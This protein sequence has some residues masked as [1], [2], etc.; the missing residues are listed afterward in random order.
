MLL[1]FLKSLLR[2]RALA[3]EGDYPVARQVRLNAAHARA[4]IRLH[5]EILYSGLRIGGHEI[6]SLVE[7]ALAQTA[8]VLP[9]LKALHRPLASFF[10]ARY[11]LH[12][13]RL[14]GMQAECGVFQGTSALLLCRAAQADEPRYDGERL[15]LVDS[16]EGLSPPTHQDRFRVTGNGARATAAVGAGALSGSFQT[17]T[18]ALAAFPAARIHKGWIPEVLAQLPEASWSFVHVDVDLYEPTYAC[19]DFFYPRLCPGG[20]IVCDDYGS[21]LFPGA[22]RAWDRYCAERAIPFVA[23]DTGQSVIIREQ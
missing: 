21:A 9:P 20:V 13:R 11:F 12:A 18:A 22:A 14:S 5:Q 16:F 17:A 6:S 23:L 3:K 19:L 10:L 8:S 2:S 1:S 15:H 7:T 4:P